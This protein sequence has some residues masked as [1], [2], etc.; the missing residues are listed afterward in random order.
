MT[1]YEVLNAIRT[2]TYQPPVYTENGPTNPTKIPGDDLLGEARRLNRSCGR[3]I[4]FLRTGEVHAK[5]TRPQMVEKCRQTIAHLENVCQQLDPGTTDGYDDPDD[6]FADHCVET[7]KYEIAQQ[8][9][10]VHER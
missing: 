10:P 1:P 8:E 4:E 9:R 7:W 2:N 3:Q 6:E 5:L